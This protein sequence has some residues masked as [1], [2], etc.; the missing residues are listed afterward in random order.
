M[1]YIVAGMTITNDVVFADGTKSDCHLGGAIFSL[2]GVRTY[3]DDVLY[4][5]N[6]GDDFEEY[7]GEWMARNNMK[8]DGMSKVLEHTHYN[9]VKYHP[10]GTYYEYSIYG[11][12]FEAR[13]REATWI[14]ADQV[15]A[16]CQGAKAMYIDSH[17]KEPFW[18]RVDEVRATGCQILWEPP[19]KCLVDPEVR[20]K[21]W[22]IID[23]VDMY[24]M[25]RPESFAFFGVDSEEAVL[26]KL[27]EYGKPCFYRVG[28]K[29]SYMVSGGEYAFAPSIDIGEFVDQTGCGNCSTAAAM[30]AYFEGYDNLMV[31]VMA[32]I[33][34]GYNLLQYGPYPYFTPEVTADAL[35]LAEKTCAELRA[36]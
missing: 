16:V 12:E 7:Y 30:Y 25:N 10:D 5:S 23:K 9:I 19:T 4:V 36:K 1:K 14:N 34:A 21:T 22:K 2:E 26:E 3:T 8:L 32:N 20:E 6:V 17:E 33:A 28:S 29:G 18:R 11:P 31:A 13:N 24:T 27:L 35:A 15:L